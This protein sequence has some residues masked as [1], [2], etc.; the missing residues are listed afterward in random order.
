MIIEKIN[1]KYNIIL[2]SQSTRRKELLQKMNINFDIKSSNEKELFPKEMN[3]ELVAEFIAKQKANHISKKLNENF[4]LIT[5]DTIVI[6]NNNIFHKP[7]TSIEAITYLKQISNKKHKVITG[8]CLKS[9][10]KEISFSCL[11]KVYFN[12]LEEEE[13]SN[14]INK[15]NPYDKAGSYGIQDWIGYIG[16]KKINGSFNNVVGLPTHLLYQKLKLF[17]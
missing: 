16:V 4:L 11:T 13:I 2:G 9:Q 1:N 6:Q 17:I 8:V 15:N 12:K 7:K 5:A 3:K 14:Y 10:E